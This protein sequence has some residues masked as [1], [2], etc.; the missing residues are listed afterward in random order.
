VRN[1]KSD[2]SHAFRQSIR[3]ILSLTRVARGENLIP[4]ILMLIIV[5]PENCKGDVPGS[6]RDVKV[7]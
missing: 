4:T 3:Q 1:T 6:S 5:T 2:K 7:T